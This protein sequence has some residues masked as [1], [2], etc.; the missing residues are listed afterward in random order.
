MIQISIESVG[1]PT[2]TET[3]GRDPEL[4]DLVRRAQREDADDHVELMG[5]FR[6]RITGFYIRSILRQPDSEEDAAHSGRGRLPP[7]APGDKFPMP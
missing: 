1:V 3:A 2:S 6:R 5:R 7:V 4:I